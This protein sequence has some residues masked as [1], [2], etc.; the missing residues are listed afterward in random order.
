MV[1]SAVMI[2]R[3]LIS[4]G[5]RYMGSSTS[6]Q[7]WLS[8]GGSLG[9]SQQIQIPKGATDITIQVDRELFKPLSTLTPPLNWLFYS[10]R[11]I[12]IG[13]VQIVQL[14]Y[15]FT[16]IRMSDDNDTGVIIE[17]FIFGEFY[18]RIKTIILRNKFFMVLLVQFACN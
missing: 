7:V 2:Y 4:T 1:C 15:H 6:A 13:A 5:R 10:I 12:L 16:V 8:L 18:Q 9:Q 3:I 11:D 14:M 17:T